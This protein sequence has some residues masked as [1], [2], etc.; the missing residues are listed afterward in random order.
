MDTT[1]SNPPRSDG[2]AGKAPEPLAPKVGKQVRHYWLAIGMVTAI[3]LLAL[4]FWWWASHRTAQASYTTVPVTRG[5]ISRDVIATG[6]INPELTIVVG[7]Y[8]SGV[9]QDLQCDYNTIVKTGQICATIDPRPYQAIV[10]QDE[11]NLAVAVAQLHKDQANLTYTQLN[12]SRDQRLVD[13]KAV[14]QDVVDIAK[15][16]TDQAQ[17]QIALDQAT[18]DQRTA[19]LSAA[20]INLDYTNIRSP[21]DGIIV[22]RNVSQGQTVASSFQT[23][24]LFLI[25]SDLTKMQVDTNVSESDIGTIRNGQEATF[26]VDAFPGRNFEG[27]ITQV[28]QSPQTVQ[29][30]VTFDAVVGAAN[31]DL[32]LKPGMTASLRIVTDKRD[33]VVRVPNQALQFE[34]TSVVSSSNAESGTPQATAGTGA[35]IWVLR[36]GKMVSVPVVTGLEDETYTEIIKGDLQPGETAITGQTGTQSSLS[37]IQAARP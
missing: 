16:L 15:N 30:V 11:A 33:N 5:S 3:V 4:G 22:S 28:R 17:A 8:V 25:A 14:S 34:P 21:V 24:T 9:I 10:N 13:T 23:P 12:Y 6:T 31:Q 37:A 35:A 36:G 20:Q 7:S 2:A 18:I 29:N 1:V 19:E 26:T 27:L 32:A